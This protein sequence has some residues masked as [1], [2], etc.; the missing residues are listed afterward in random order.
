[1]T[2]LEGAYEACRRLQRRHDPTFYWAC[3]RLPGDVRPAV[4]ALYG[5]VRLADEIADAPASI[6]DPTRACAALDD[7]QRALCD[8]RE[9]GSSGHP[10]IAALVDAERR[11]DL[12]LHE[13]DAYMDS[14]RIDCGSVRFQ[15]TEE[16]DTY[17]N[18]SA[19]SVGRIMA[20]LLG[21]PNAGEQVAQL[22]LGFQLTN[23]IRDVRQDWD[24]GRVYLPGL[25]GEDLC[26]RPGTDRLRE[27]VAQEVERARQMFAEGAGTMGVVN[28]AVRPAMRVAI[29]VYSRVL[30]R[31]ERLNFDVVGKRA[32]LSPWDIATT[33]ATTTR[34]Y[35]RSGP[36]LH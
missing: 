17:M 18:G 9:T 36:P 31:V 29:A 8:G 7:W 14:M 23:F 13:L 3:R 22:G 24:M 1:M 28:P 27:R 2:D 12:P 25:N 19:A 11:H 21:A 32:A 5:F 33:L 6:R 4:Y 26:R 16:L 34:A 15:T 20:P 10:V 35:R 30:D